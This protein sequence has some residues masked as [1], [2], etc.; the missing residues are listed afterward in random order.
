[1]DI[2]KLK[3]DLHCLFLTGL[4]LELGQENALKILADVPTTQQCGREVG[5]SG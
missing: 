5:P 1:M 4:I 2:K 3:A